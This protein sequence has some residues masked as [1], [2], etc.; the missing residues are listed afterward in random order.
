MAR[1]QILQLPAKRSST[2]I[3]STQDL[4]IVEY[5]LDGTNPVQRDSHAV[6]GQVR[7]HR[8]ITDA[9]QEHQGSTT[10]SVVSCCDSCTSESRT[11]CVMLGLPRTSISQPMAE[12]KHQCQCQADIRTLQHTMRA[13][14]GPKSGL[15]CQVSSKSDAQKYYA[16][17]LGSFSNSSL[18]VR[19][20]HGLST[21][22]AKN[23]LSISL[24]CQAYGT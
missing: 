15:Y 14:V 24:P 4:I 21:L 19:L 12:E 1:E 22:K 2:N 18:E 9:E 3:E 23:S 13:Q 20:P 7:N 16:Y 10:G 6:C 8:T 11:P 17:L 5:T